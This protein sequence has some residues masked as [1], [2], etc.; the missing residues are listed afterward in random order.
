MLYS[1]SIYKFVFILW[2]SMWTFLSFTHFCALSF[3]WACPLILECLLKQQ[4]R[5]RWRNVVK[6]I[7]CRDAWTHTLKERLP[8]FLSLVSEQYICLWHN[9]QH[10]CFVLALCV[11]IALRFSW[12]K[13]WWFIMIVFLSLFFI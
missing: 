13:V 9:S 12:N 3:T 11:C 4:R 7:R 1:P 6:M 10:L 2:I 5:W 8:A